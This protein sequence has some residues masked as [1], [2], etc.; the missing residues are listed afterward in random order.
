MCLYI[1]DKQPRVAKKDITVLKYVRLC[2][3][4]I[5]SPYQFTKIPVNEIMTAY[6]DKED[7]YYFY[8]TDLFDNKIYSLSGGAIH[9]KL[10]K[11]GIS[12][13]EARKAIIPAG[14]KYWLSICGT[15]IAARSMIITDINWD[16]GDNKVSE[17]I[18]DEILDNAPGVNGV[19]IGDYLLDNGE[20]TRPQKGLSKDEVVGIVSG[21]HN[22]EPLIAA[23]TFYISA[24]DRLYNSNFGE[25]NNI[26]R[27][28]IKEFNGKSITKKYKEGDRDSRFE[29]FEACIKYRKD[30]NEEWYFGAAGEVATMLDN[31][32]YLN[33]AH[34]I[35][36]LGF[37][38]GDEWYNSC[39]ECSHDYSWACQLHDVRVYCH[40]ERKHNELRTVPFLDLKSLSGTKKIE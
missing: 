20:Y 39:S 15:E 29:A 40:W 19:R 32:I 13:C 17:S 38:I 25:N 31:C 5:I 27:D 24:Y 8:S 23:L 14:T 4:D 37:V 33:A 26:E 3:N 16:N 6:P 36:G 1:R 34:Q 7:I 18:F 30:K 2:D 35:T 11:N 9:A 10:I 28:A 12:G 22:R 21:F